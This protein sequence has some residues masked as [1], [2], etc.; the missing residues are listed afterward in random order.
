[1]LEP[2]FSKVFAKLR[3]WVIPSCRTKMPLAQLFSM[4]SRLVQMHA[5]MI[6]AQ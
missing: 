1:M 2:C 4:M 3:A 6:I 5:H